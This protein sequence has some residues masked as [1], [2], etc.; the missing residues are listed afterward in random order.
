MRDVLAEQ[1]DLERER[2]AELES[3][4]QE[5]AARVW[6][7]REAEWER[8]RV[9]REQLM[10]EVFRVRE[11]QLEAK[12]AAIREQRREALLDRQRILKDVEIADRIA[13]EQEDEAEV[14]KQLTKR[15]IETQRDQRVERL[16][17]QRLREREEEEAE[18]KERRD[19]DELLAKESQRFRINGGH[20]AD[21]DGDDAEETPRSERSS[22]IGS[23]RSRSSVRSN[24][25]WATHE[26]VVERKPNEVR[27]TAWS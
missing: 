2:E 11:E 27:K 1:M 19:Y 21:D 4:Y 14:A 24:P 26:D 9:A 10:E 15:D 22:V 7:K 3:M 25:P 20:D 12:V 23:S 8:E 16:Q 18:E 5:E 17:L 6:Q 13:K